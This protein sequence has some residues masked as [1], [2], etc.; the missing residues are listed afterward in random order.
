MEKNQQYSMMSVSMLLYIDYF[1][2]NVYQACAYIEIN[3]TTNMI[4]Q[5]FDVNVLSSDFQLFFFL[6]STD[7]DK[8][9]NKL[10]HKSA[11]YRQHIKHI[12]MFPKQIMTLHAQC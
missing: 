11:V 12:Y 10:A 9:V 3:F 1:V 4:Q 6:S 2:Q 5:N 8:D 7:S